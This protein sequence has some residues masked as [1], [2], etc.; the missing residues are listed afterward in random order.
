MRT[1]I[2]VLLTTMMSCGQL[3]Q[4]QRQNIKEGIKET[5]IECLLDG[6]KVACEVLLDKATDRMQ[7]D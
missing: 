7:N 3:T 5:A 6:A 2:I 1:L 4:Q